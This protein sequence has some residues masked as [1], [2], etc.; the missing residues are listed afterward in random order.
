LLAVKR[1]KFWA[2]LTRLARITGVGPGLG[3]FDQALH[4]GADRYDVLRNNSLVETTG[5]FMFVL[6]SPGDLW[7]AQGHPPL[8]LTIHHPSG[9]ARTFT[10]AGTRKPKQRQPDMGLIPLHL[11]MLWCPADNSLTY[12]GGIRNLT[13]VDSAGKLMA[14]SKGAESLFFSPWNQN[15]QVEFSFNLF[16]PRPP[17]GVRSIGTIRGSVPIIISFD[18]M[19]W[20]INHLSSGNASINIDRLKWRFG[21]PIYADNAWKTLL[22]IHTDVLDRQQADFL[23]SFSQRVRNNGERA[24]MIKSRANKHWE[25]PSIIDSGGRGTDYHFLLTV[26]GSQPVSARVIIY[27]CQGVKMN[28]PFEFRKVSVSR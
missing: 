7:R 23:A 27:R 20:R 13:I 1:R 26:A 8:P 18:P 3:F 10:G 17:A 19:T 28:V 21:K 2:V 4:F 12:V 24:V 5:A 14:L 16:L 15:R 22:T 11:D 6:Q 25:T 9:P